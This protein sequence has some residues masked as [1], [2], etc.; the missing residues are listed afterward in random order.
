MTKINKI[1][2]FAKKPVV[3]TAAILSA[4]ALTGALAAAVTSMSGLASQMQSTTSA[5]IKIVN[6]VAIVGGVFLV[7]H[8]ILKLRS[9]SQNPQQVPMG[10]GVCACLVGAAL[11]CFPVLLDIG[12]KT[13]SGDTKKSDI[14]GST[15]SG[16]FNKSG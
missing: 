15:I 7:A 8:G 13:V 10:H 6:N 1:M 16:D 11:I 3:I 9:H 2:R 12:A 14:K 5:L 4:C